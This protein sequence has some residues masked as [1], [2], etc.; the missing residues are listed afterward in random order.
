MLP[1][2]TSS[3][4]NA[5]APNAAESHGSIE[6]ESGLSSTPC[7]RTP[8][9]STPSLPSMHPSGRNVP[10]SSEV[11]VA[12]L[13]SRPRLAQT[14]TRCSSAAEDALAP[15]PPKL[16]DKSQ[17]TYGGDVDCIPRLLCRLSRSILAQGRACSRIHSPGSS[18]AAAHRALPSGDRS[19]KAPPKW[20]SSGSS[21]ARCSFKARETDALKASARSRR[22]L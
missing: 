9:S 4:R 19:R 5:P 14:S 11:G 2:S 21:A 13:S 1:S 7:A 17:P 6:P 3:T 18:S 15:V 8:S 20:S 16:E 22:R 12:W 10:V